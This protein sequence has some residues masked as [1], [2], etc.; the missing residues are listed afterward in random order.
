MTT[1]ILIAAV[2]WLAWSNGA[3]DNF[4]G[5]AT[6][7]GSG[8]TTFRRALIWATAAMVLGSVASVYLATVLVKRFSGAGMVPAELIDSAWLIAVSASAAATIP[9]YIST[10]SHPKASKKPWSPGPSR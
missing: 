2:L 5:V 3:N 7:Y 6:L 1:G 9:S 4:K 10:T 8:T